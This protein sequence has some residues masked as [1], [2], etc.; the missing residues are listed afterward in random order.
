MN[1]GPSG[2]RSPTVPV[3]TSV[4]SPPTMRG[5]ARRRSPIAPPTS[6]RI[7][8]AT[9]PR[10]TYASRL[11]RSRMAA[12]TVES[13]GPQTFGVETRREQR[14]HA[15]EERGPGLPIVE[16]VGEDLGQVQARHTAR[17]YRPVIDAPGARAGGDRAPARVRAAAS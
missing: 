13:D 9:T 10:R 12:C 2:I 11:G 16:D 14:D 5:R 15:R 6:S 3:T 17:C 8:D 1:S 4:A 7:A